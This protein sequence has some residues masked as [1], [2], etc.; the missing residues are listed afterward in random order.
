[1]KSDPVVCTVSKESNVTDSTTK[2]TLNFYL[3]YGTGEY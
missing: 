2:K 1:M 3:C